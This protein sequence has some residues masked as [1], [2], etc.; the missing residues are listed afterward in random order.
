MANCGNSCKL[1]WAGKPKSRQWTD[2]GGKYIPHPATWL[3]NH[4]W[5]D[6]PIKA[7]DKANKFAWAEEFMASEHTEP[8]TVEVVGV[9]P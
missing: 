1:L 3:N 9:A 2:E 6:Q 7:A 5:E 4:R 8:V